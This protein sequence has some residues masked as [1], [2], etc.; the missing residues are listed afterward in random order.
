MVALK[1]AKLLIC[2]L[3]LKLIIFGKNE[4]KIMLFVKINEKYGRNEI[5]EVR[6]YGKTTQITNLVRKFNCEIRWAFFAIKSKLNLRNFVSSVN[7]L[8][9]IRIILILANDI[10]LNPGPNFNEC[11]VCKKRNKNLIMQCQK[12]NKYCHRICSNISLNQFR[13]SDFVFICDQCSNFIEI[14]FNF[15]ED[16]FENDLENDLRNC[17]ITKVIPSNLYKKRH[18]KIVHFNARSAISKLDELKFFCQQTNVDILCLSE[19]W[20]TSNSTI[21]E[22]EINGYYCYRNDK[23]KGGG[24]CLYIRNT[25][26]GCEIK[27]NAKYLQVIGA[28]INLN[29][30]KKV[31]VFCIYKPHNVS[32]E[33]CATDLDK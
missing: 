28:T 5:G 19:T 8:S 26:I 15:S 12:C 33:N 18:F 4:E 3:T 29:K 10:E 22:T 6:I 13:S 25:Y 9:I 32:F 21:H 24:V 1:T 17:N 23:G 11:A 7:L 2:L 31:S 27:M 14:P 30:F 20:F 16:F